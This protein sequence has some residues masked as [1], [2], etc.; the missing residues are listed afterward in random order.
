MKSEASKDDKTGS[1]IDT[2]ISTFEAIKEAKEKEEGFKNKTMDWETSKK[3][4]AL[5][6]DCLNDIKSTYCKVEDLVYNAAKEM[7]Q[8]EKSR[9][10]TKEN[11]SEKPKSSDRDKYQIGMKVKVRQNNTNRTK[12]S[13]NK[14]IW[15]L[16]S[17]LQIDKDTANIILERRELDKLIHLNYLKLS[18]K[19]CKCIRKKWK[20]Y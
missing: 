6:D 14:Y 10:I 7:I 8:E 15:K 13:N 5:L 12:D 3:A 18:M 19:T 11:L 2:I 9:E 20:W 1:K 16:G 4:F 17:I